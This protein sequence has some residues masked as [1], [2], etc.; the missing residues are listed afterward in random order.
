MAD[1]FRCIAALNKAAGKELTPDEALEV[2][3]RIQRTARDI[4]NGKIKP[5]GDAN[6]ASPEGIMQKAAEIAA[7]ELVHDK[8][9]QQRNTQLRIAI[10][11]ERKAEVEA[12]KGG[13]I[14]DVDVRHVFD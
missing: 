1:P 4:A 8:I 7:N 13:G 10:L 12:M 3:D 6:L 9:R 11:G 14:G 5:E 2:F